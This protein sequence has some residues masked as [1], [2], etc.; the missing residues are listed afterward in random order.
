VI[1]RR[2]IDVASQCNFGLTQV[3]SPWVPSLDADWELGDEL[4]RELTSIARPESTVGYR[5]RFV[6]WIY[7]RRC[8]GRGIRGAS[9]SCER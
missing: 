8:A 2:F 6:Y 7:E 5:A 9:S 3:T 4:V 1:N